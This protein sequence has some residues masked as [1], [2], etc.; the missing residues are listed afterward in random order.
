[1]ANTNE[2]ARARVIADP[3]RVAQVPEAASG[4]FEFKNTFQVPVVNYNGEI[5]VLSNTEARLL[6]FFSQNRD[7]GMTRFEIEKH[8]GWITDGMEDSGSNLLSRSIGL[9]RG[10]LEYPMEQKSLRRQEFP[11]IGYQIISLKKY[12]YLFTNPNSSADKP[13]MS[14]KLNGFIPWRSFGV[15]NTNDKVTILTSGQMAL[16]AM[17]HLAP[18]AG[19]NLTK[20]SIFYGEKYIHLYDLLPNGDLSDNLQQLLNVLDPKGELGSNPFRVGSEHVGG[21]HRTGTRGK[22][23][24]MR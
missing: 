24:F 7:I 23:S 21:G 13:K 12:G 22:Y 6:Q 18:P 4:I 19:D 20:L 2:T 3:A 10:K 9:L 11:D 16:L 15:V 8:M 17:L 5:A 1:L 14:E